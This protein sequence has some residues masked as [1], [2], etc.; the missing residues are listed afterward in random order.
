MEKL[1]DGHDG[2]WQGCWRLSKPRRNRAYQWQGDAIAQ[3]VN[4]DHHE[5]QRHESR[6]GK[7]RGKPKRR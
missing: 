2:L 1:T 6:R 3:N 7:T 5:S 4:N